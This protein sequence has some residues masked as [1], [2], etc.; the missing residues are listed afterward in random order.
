MTIVIVVMSAVAANEISRGAMKM[1]KDH[2]GPFE[3]VYIIIT[4]TRVRSKPKK[5][6]YSLCRIPFSCM[7]EQNQL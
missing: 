6:H 1:I 5:M 4:I 2:E 3:V 7:Q